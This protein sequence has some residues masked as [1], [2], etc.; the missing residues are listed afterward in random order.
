MGHYATKCPNKRIYYAVE[1]MLAEEE[2]REI[3]GREGP[4]E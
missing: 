1:T 4:Q 2:L 3:S